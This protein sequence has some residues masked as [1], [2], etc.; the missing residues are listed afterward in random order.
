MTV[1]SLC[2]CRY[3]ASFHVILYNLFSCSGE[4]LRDG[5]Y[6]GPGDSGGDVRKAQGWWLAI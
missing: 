5:V 3:I 6:R 4:A 1:L 2:L